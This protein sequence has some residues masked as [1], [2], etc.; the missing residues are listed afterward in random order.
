HGEPKVIGDF[1]SK[2][3]VYSERFDLINQRLKR[4]SGYL[5]RF[6][7]SNKFENKLSSLKDLRGREGEEFTIFGLLIFS[8][9]KY[10]LEDK[11]WRIWLDLSECEMRGFYTEG[12]FVLAKGRY[13]EVQK[14]K[15][16]SI[17][18][19]PL[20]DPDDTR[21]EFGHLD[22]LGTPNSLENE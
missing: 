14:F 9:E 19:P 10:Q 6:T 8:D 7:S 3:P 4:K 17:E 5:K 15:A 11:D 2:A 16:T 12:N 22:F 18:H 1:S 13:I 20:E 21:R